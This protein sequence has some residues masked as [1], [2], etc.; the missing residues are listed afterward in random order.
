MEIPVSRLIRQGSHLVEPTGTVKYALEEKPAITADAFALFGG[1]PADLA[2]ANK[3]AFHYQAVSTGTGELGG[4]IHGEINAPGEARILHVSTKEGHTR[5]GV[6]SGLLDFCIEQL[7]LR[8]VK[9]VSLADTSQDIVTS[10]PSGIYRTA[11]FTH[12]RGDIYERL[13]A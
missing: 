5:R 6:A 2:Q 4:N 11:Q 7:G 13:I 10:N 8:G 12:V 3:Q 9:R 1:N